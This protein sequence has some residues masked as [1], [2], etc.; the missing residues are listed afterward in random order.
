M[1]MHIGVGAQHVTGGTPRRV[2]WKTFD[3][4]S[5]H[6]DGG[7]GAGGNGVIGAW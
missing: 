7:G 1:R 3:E 4:G 2:E 5:I 6:N